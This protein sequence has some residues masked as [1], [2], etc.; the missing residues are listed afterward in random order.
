MVGTDFESLVASHDQADL[1]CLPVLK[2]TNI[3]CSSFLP[4]VSTG[5]K[6]KELCAPESGRDKVVNDAVPPMMKALQGGRDLP[7]F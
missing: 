2:Q 5:I 6:P 1:L 3:A 7:T 4:L